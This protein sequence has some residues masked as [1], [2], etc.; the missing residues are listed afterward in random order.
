MDEVVWEV[1]VFRRFRLLVVFER[2]MT[3]EVV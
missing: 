2:F 3:L 1:D